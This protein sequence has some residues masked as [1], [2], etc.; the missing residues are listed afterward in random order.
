M[1]I[2]IFANG[3][4][5]DTPTG[6]DKIFV[7]IA[8]R[9]VRMGHDVTAVTNEAG[10]SYCR[11]HGLSQKRLILWPSSRFDR[12]NVY[13]SMFYKA[14]VGL[15]YGMRQQYRQPGIIFASSLFSQDM[16]PAWI[17]KLRFKDAALGTACYLFTTKLFGSDYSAGRLKGFLFW[18]NEKIAF[19]LTL[20]F[21]NFLVTA[22]DFDRRE[23]IRLHRFPRQKVLALRGGVDTDFF[24]SVSR[25]K[26]LYDAVFVG[27]FH[28]QKCI[29]ELISIWRTVTDSLPGSR[30][31]LVGAGQEEE[32]LRA[33]VRTMNLGENVV[34]LGIREG[35]EKTK[36]L[37]ASKLFVSASRFDSGN[38]ALD[39]ALGC[40]VPG[41]IYD[42]PR[43]SYPSGVVKVPVGDSRQF[44]GQILWFLEHAKMR[45]KLG[46]AALEFSQS[47]DWD[48]K[49]RHLL[50]F[51]GRSSMQ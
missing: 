6:G 20:R 28:P 47:L 32:R 10:A 14:W 9:W 48:A 49:A 25:Q 38:I 12:V 31:A 4:Y 33:M 51:I 45:E 15:V 30:L 18:L 37:K 29:D 2:L 1:N 27:R 13:I 24:R 3:I 23:F 21:G 44:A 19:F 17:A 35:V 34:F 11:Q 46:N 26:N 40:G 5:T 41:I 39:E 7:E 42:L 36:V 43:L 16:L 50:D 8:K 22:S